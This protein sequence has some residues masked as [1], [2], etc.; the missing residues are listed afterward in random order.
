MASTEPSQ[1]RVRLMTS[2]FLAE[3]LYAGDDELAARLQE[4]RDSQRHTPTTPIIDMVESLLLADRP[5]ARRT[6]KEQAATV[7]LQ[8]SSRIVLQLQQ[9]LANE[10]AGDYM[11]VRLKELQLLIQSATQAA[12]AEQALEPSTSARVAINSTATE[13]FMMGPQDAS[14]VAADAAPALSARSSSV[15]A[16]LSAPVMVHEFSKEVC[17]HGITAIPSLHPP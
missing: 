13:T 8:E 9:D 15:Q 16:V 17:E 7:A 14:T 2:A 11:Q 4:A 12:V 6:L 5:A 1:D 3:A 10:G